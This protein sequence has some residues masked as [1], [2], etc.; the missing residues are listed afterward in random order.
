MTSRTR[1]RAELEETMASTN[2]ML[3]VAARRIA[4]LAA[5][6]DTTSTEFDSHL[7]MYRKLNAEFTEAKSEYEDLLATR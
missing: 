3:T 1:T 7:S 6:G 5:A 4:E 2:G